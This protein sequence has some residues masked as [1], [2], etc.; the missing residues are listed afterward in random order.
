MKNIKDYLKVDPTSPSGLR[1]TKTANSRAKENTSAGT[2]ITRGYWQIQF[3][4]KRYMAHSLVLE[5]SGVSRP[6]GLEPDHINGVR[7]D[8]RIENLRWVSRKRNCQ[9][10]ERTN[11]TNHRWVLQNTN[12]STFR[13]QVWD[14]SK[15]HYMSGFATPEEA[16]SAALAKRKELGLPIDTRLS[17]VH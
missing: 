11:S 3:N 10:Q 14:G 5:L 13:Y 7:S 9:N 12:C 2:L 6:E 4:K 15:Q 17:T 1:W 8:N 16:H